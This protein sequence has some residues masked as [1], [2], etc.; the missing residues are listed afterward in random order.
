MTPSFVPLV[1][2]A[3][4]AAKF[5]NAGL[6]HRNLS[7]T[8]KAQIGRRL[9][10]Y[11]AEQAHERQREG[12]REGGKTAGNGRT[13]KSSHMAERPE[14]KKAHDGLAREMA[15]KASGAS[16]RQIARLDRLER[17]ADPALYQAVEE[18]RISATEAESYL[19]LNKRTQA[20][21]AGVANP[22]ACTSP[23]AAARIASGTTPA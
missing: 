23:I 1:G 10:A 21:I 9:K 15:A 17:E 18:E 16:G 22:Q 12:A 8:Q 6:Q 3:E 7:A 11:F 4:D 20:K 13:R 14:G 2:S 5:V 19:H